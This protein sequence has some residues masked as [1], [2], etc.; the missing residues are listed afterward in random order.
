MKT[1]KKDYFLDIEDF[2]LWNWRKCHNEELIYARRNIEIG[3]EKDDFDAFMMIKQSNLDEFGI[4]KDFNHLLNLMEELALLQCDLVIT[5]E[6]FLKNEIKRLETEIELILN[7]EV[8]NDTDTALIHLSK[9]M[10]VM[11]NDKTITVKMFHKMLN[12]YGKDN[13][14]D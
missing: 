6:R 13:K 4:N 8:E 9:W 12:E 11:L 5:Q 2:P 14:K 7:R 3:N 10:G 1:L